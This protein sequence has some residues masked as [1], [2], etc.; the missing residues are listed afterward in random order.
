MRYVYVHLVK[1]NF[2]F[3]QGR[4]L[5]SLPIPLVAAKNVDA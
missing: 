4:N 1:N 5:S 2:I 3:N